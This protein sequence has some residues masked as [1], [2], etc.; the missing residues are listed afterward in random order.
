ML[1]ALKYGFSNYFN[2]SGT[3]GR[4]LF[5]LWVLSIFL[6]VFVLGLIDVLVVD[7]A[8]GVPASGPDVQNPLA[9]LFSLFVIIPNIA[10]GV[11]RLRDAGYSPW[12]MLLGLIPFVNLILIYFYVQ[13]SVEMERG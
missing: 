6:I 7:P 8:L 1:E 11:R 13:P 10:M 12:L 5:W 9:W 4:R 3:T 2:F